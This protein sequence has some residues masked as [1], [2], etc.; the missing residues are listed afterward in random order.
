LNKFF[1]QLDTDK[2]ETKKISVKQAK[3]IFK[4][5][6]MKFSRIACQLLIKQNESWHFTDIACETHVIRESE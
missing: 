3:T 5:Y 1:S 6:N 4:K 2:D